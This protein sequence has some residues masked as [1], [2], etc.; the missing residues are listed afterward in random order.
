MEM[1]YSLITLEAWVMF[2]KTRRIIALSVITIIFS[3][4]FISNNNPF[5]LFVWLCMLY[6]FMYHTKVVFHIFPDYPRSNTFPNNF[7]VSFYIS[8]VDEYYGVIRPST[9][10]KPLTKKNTRE[11]HT[12]TKNLLP[13]DDLL[14]GNGFKP[15]NESFIRKAAQFRVLEN[16]RNGGKLFQAQALPNSQ[17][18]TLGGKEWIHADLASANYMDNLVQ[19]ESLGKDMSKHVKGGTK[20]FT[21]RHVSASVGALAVCAGAIIGGTYIFMESYP[22][23]SKVVMKGLNSGQDLPSPEEVIKDDIDLY[24]ESRESYKK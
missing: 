16:S 11:Y 21:Y 3:A 10:V 6:T 9:S 4:N 13:G 8:S 5:F 12:T 19:K 7:D 1:V 2:S 18:G 15:H 14:S 22:E 17:L 23:I 24:L 20:A